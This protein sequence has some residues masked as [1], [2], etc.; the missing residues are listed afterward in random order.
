MDAEQ[1]RKWDA[2]AQSHIERALAEYTETLIDGVG[3]ALSTIR[4]E[5]R[6]HVAEEIARVRA[7]TSKAMTKKF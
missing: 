5:Y 2:W 1:Q 7:L 3:E 4:Q 6:A